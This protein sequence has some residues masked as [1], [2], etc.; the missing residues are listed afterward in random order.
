M[1]GS[2][3]PAFSEDISSL[4]LG[5]DNCCSGWHT[6]S[7]STYTKSLSWVS[8]RVVNLPN[9]ISIRQEDNLIL[10]GDRKV[11]RT[12]ALLMSLFL[13]DFLICG[14]VPVCW[15]AV[16]T[17]QRQTHKAFCSPIAAVF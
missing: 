14:K 1:K 16:L 17:G 8:A 5:F 12:E 3:L 2:P 11:A 10:S 13:S 4:I 6:C 9:S 7:G 15:L